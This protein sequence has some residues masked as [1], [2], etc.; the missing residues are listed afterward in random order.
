MKNRL[1]PAIVALA[2]CFLSHA[3]QGNFDE[4]TDAGHGLYKVKTHDRWG[5]VDSKD[6]LKLSIEYNEPLFMN[7]YA[8]ITNYGTKQLAGVIDSVGNFRALPGYYVNMAHPFV[9]NNMLAVRESPEGN[10]GFLNTRTG[11]LLKPRI[12]DNGKKGKILK[13]LGLS[14]KGAKGSFAFDF[15]APFVDGIAVV[16]SPK[17]GWHHM[18]T[19]GMERFVDTGEKPNAFRSSV[20]RGQCVIY[21]DKGIVVCKESPAHEAWIVGYLADSH[22][23]KD[24]CGELS[25]PYMVRSGDTRL[26]LNS[27]LQAEKFENL[28]RGDSVILIERPKIKAAAPAKKASGFKLSRDIKVETSKK[29]VAAN[30]KGSATVT[31]NVTNTGQ[32]DS[33]EL[34]VSVVV[35][36]VKKEW[37]GTVAKGATQ[38]ISVSVPAKFSTAS[39]TC[40]VSFSVSDSGDELTG[41]DAVTIRRYKPSRR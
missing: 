24:F 34:E 26:T 3:F 15:V 19:N 6:N 23:D 39:I 1:I 7:G 40:D 16:H 36:G 2:T 18:D 37:S 8:V 38:Q 30:A 10:W 25:Y 20:Y 14:G 27:R 17:T 21:G 22:D 28:S 32:T 13:S 12:K 5:I 4:K 31:V 33:G 9:S 41:T 29:S 11:D 35:R